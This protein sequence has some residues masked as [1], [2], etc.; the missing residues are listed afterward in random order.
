MWLVEIGYSR[1]QQCQLGLPCSRTAR[2][3]HGTSGI[4]S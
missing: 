3:Q 2:M 1:S 4:V